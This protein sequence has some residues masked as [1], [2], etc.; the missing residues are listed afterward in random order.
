MGRMVEQTGLNERLR[1]QGRQSGMLI[2][3]SMALTIV[4]TIGAFVWIFFRI[5]PWLTDFTGRTGARQ[6]SPIARATQLARP[7]GVPAGASPAGVAPAVTTGSPAPAGPP[8]V[9]TPTALILPSPTATPGFTATHQ[10]ADFG[11][12]VNLR[13]GPTASSGR[14]ALLAP[15]TK[16]KFLNQQESTGDVIWMK[17]E[18]ERGDV[19]WIRSLDV[20]SAR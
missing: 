3:L 17:F 12:R 5:D 20:R 8:A 2:G 4:L 19:G 10:V 13:A 11:E 15:G 6:G 1:Q 18:T 9:P 16:L 14:I 7:V